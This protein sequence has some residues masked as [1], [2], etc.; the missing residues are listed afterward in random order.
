MF[1]RAALNLMRPYRPLGYKIQADAYLA[2][3]AHLL[4]G[5]LFLTKPLIYRGIHRRQRLRL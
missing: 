1:R 2:Q 5:T 4:G 3:G